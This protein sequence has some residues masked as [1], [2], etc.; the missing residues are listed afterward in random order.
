MRES[1]YE[2]GFCFDV[3]YAPVGAQA[4]AV[5]HV[6][7]TANAC[8]SSLFVLEIYTQAFFSLPGRDKMHGSATNPHITTE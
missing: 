5:E 2:Y 1:S 4:L 7:S 3:T 8:A 6:C